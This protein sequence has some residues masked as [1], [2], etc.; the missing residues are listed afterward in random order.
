MN[1]LMFKDV[2]KALNAGENLEMARFA[3]KH[4]AEPQRRALVKKYPGYFKVAKTGRVTVNKNAAITE[5]VNTTTLSKRTLEMMDKSM[6]GI[7]GAKN[8]GTETASYT[9]VLGGYGHE[10][11]AQREC[12]QFR[13]PNVF[14][15]QSAIFPDPR[16]HGVEVKVTSVKP[17]KLV[18]PSS[19]LY[20]WGVE[21]TLAIAGPSAKVAHWMNTF[22]AR[23]RMQVAR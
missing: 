7:K 5:P 12:Q 11:A 20:P 18:Q 15:Y 4:A 17:M 3:F 13:H 21:L 19:P 23:T 9:V 1:E 8:D 14:I 2:L 6:K 16:T 22:Q 10:A